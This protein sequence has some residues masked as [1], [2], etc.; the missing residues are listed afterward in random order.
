MYWHWHS[1]H[2]AI[3]SYWKGV[4]SHDFSDN[5]TYKEASVIGKEWAKIGDRLRNLK[6]KN[7][8]ALMLDNNSLTGLQQFPLHT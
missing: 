2:N 1:I 7:S 8:V 3:E 6:K 4:L 5:E